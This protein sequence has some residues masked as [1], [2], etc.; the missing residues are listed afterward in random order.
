MGIEI[1][2]V[3]S[4]A[5]WYT[6][7]APPVVRGLEGWF[8]FDT[9]ISRVGFNRVE[10]KADGVIVGAPVVAAAYATF[11]GLS[12]FVQ[13]AITESI[14]QTVILVS[15]ANTTIPGGASVFGDANTPMHAGT[16]EGASANSTYPGTVPGAAVYQTEQTTTTFM[17]SRRNAGDTATTGDVLSLTG[18]TATNWG[19]RVLRTSSGAGN[20]L[21]N[22]TLG[23]V[24]TSTLISLRIPTTNTWR[25]GSGYTGFAG[26]VDVSQ[27]IIFSTLLTD[28]E[29]AALAVPIRARAARLGITV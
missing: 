9:D 24:V 3:G 10:G 14:E 6:K 18:E 27:C 11:T 16:Y 28:E 17:A 21:N 4:P 1:I 8:N 15:R 23:S 13:T 7:V 22:L 20:K 26:P 25:I 12:A 19:L 2:S 5:P 29:I